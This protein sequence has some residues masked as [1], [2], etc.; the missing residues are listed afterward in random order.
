MSLSRC[1]QHFPSPDD[2]QLDPRLDALLERLSF[3]DEVCYF[4]LG[5]Q[6]GEIIDV[7]AT[8]SDEEAK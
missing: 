8:A 7:E 6:T 2:L 5:D 1:N 3:F 4:G